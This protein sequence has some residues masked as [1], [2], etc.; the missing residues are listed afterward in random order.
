[1][2]FRVAGTGLEPATAAVWSVSPS[3]GGHGTLVT[4]SGTGFGATQGS[5]S[6]TISGAPCLFGAGSS[7]SAGSIKCSVQYP[8]GGKNT[9]YVNIAAAGFASVASY[10]FFTGAST[11]SSFTPATSGYGGRVPM[12][13]TGSG[14][15]SS[16][17]TKSGSLLQTMTAEVCGQ[18]CIVNTTTTTASVLRCTLPELVTAASIEAFQQSA[19]RVSQLSGKVTSANMGS[20]KLA[21]DGNLETSTNDGYWCVGSLAAV[22]SRDLPSLS[23]HRH[24]FARQPSVACLVFLV[25]IRPVC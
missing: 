24:S 21:F 5:S 14:F 4:I 10:M 9:P 16:A 6:V 3:S 15:W 17:N 13:I 20:P 11:I 18:P 22:Y 19:S 2:V 1:M 12:T 23:D 8:V 7:W 25:R